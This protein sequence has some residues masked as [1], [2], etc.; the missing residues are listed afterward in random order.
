MTLAETR[1]SLH[2]VAELLLAG[3]QHA[4]SGTIRLRV[5]PAGF[6]TVAD[7]ALRVEGTRL[8]HAAGAIDLDGRTAVDVAEECGVAATTLETVYSDGPGVL[9]TDV[10]RVDAASAAVLAAAFEVGDA[11][12]RALDPA[13]EPVLWPEHFD[14]GVSLDE[15]NYGVSP[16]D[17][18]SPVPYAYVGPW[19]PRRGEFWNAPFGASRP[20]DE[21]GGVEEV[22]A[23]FAEGR[24][25][26]A[27]DP[28]A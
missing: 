22:L 18:S 23:F 8:E 20:L 11:A 6:A 15:V 2:G 13:Q 25:R 7:P 3:P 27:A 4:R 26:A 17:S 12:L 19:V 28:R 14:V 10:L 9:A 5:S 24:A 21:L 16:G 1:R